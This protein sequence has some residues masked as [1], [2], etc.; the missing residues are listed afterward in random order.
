[1]ASIR[2]CRGAI[3]SI[4]P[5]SDMSPDI[6]NAIDDTLTEAVTVINTVADMG[7]LWSDILNQS[8][9]DDI[10]TQGDTNKIGSQTDVD[11][12]MVL[13]QRTSDKLTV[14]SSDSSESSFDLIILQRFY[15]EI[16]YD[17]YA[18]EYRY[19]S[20]G[21]IVGQEKCNFP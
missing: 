12:Y 21:D 20:T 4:D 15:T 10:A 16:S 13:V 5:G 11:V 6:A 9:Q 3:G 18:S 14:L 19:L 8:S 7:S 1:M 17:E 2:S